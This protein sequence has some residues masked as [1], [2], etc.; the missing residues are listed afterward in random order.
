MW[1]WVEKGNV[2]ECILELIPGHFLRLVKR[3]E[4]GEQTPER[5]GSVMSSVPHRIIEGELTWSSP[6]GSYRFTMVTGYVSIQHGSFCFD[7]HWNHATY[8]DERSTK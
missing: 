6:D 1:N 7:D 3:D 2:W 8:S 5:Q 4:E